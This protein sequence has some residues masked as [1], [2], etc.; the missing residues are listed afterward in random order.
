MVAS[1]WTVPDD[2]TRIL[3]T[4]FYENL[5]GAKLGRAEALRQAQL[6]QLAQN[7]HRFGQALPHTWGAFV[8]DGDWR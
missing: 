3:M 1:L 2:S 7:R 5:W 8:L 6:W 4:R